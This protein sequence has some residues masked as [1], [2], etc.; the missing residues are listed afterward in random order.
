MKTENYVIETPQGLKEEGEERIS[1]LMW[2]AQCIPIEALTFSKYA[3]PR[4]LQSSEN[5]K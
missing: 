1:A 3:C 4:P 5:R 2:K